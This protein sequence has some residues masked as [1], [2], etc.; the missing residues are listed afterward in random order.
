MAWRDMAGPL[1]VGTQPVL[2]ETLLGVDV[3]AEPEAPAPK[4]AEPELAVVYQLDLSPL[5]E[6]LDTLIALTDSILTELQRPPWY[7][8]FWLWIRDTV[9]F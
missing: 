7:T 8:R 5:L 3:P 2:G 6:K 1:S 9:R 4:P